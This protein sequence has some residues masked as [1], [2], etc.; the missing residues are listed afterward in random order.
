MRN[1]QGRLA[2]F[3]TVERAELQLSVFVRAGDRFGGRPL[4][5]EIIDRA[6]RAGLSGASVVQG[7]QGFGNSAKLRPPGVLGPNGSEPVLIE[8]LDS[9]TRVH[10]FLPVL[11]Q[12]LGS[13]L[14]V[15]KTVTVTRRVADVPDIAATP[16]P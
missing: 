14:M 3:R 12:L 7:L 4:Y 10:A 5:R 1:R 13:G 16:A 2:E 11:D 8:I 15:L 6:R 9:P